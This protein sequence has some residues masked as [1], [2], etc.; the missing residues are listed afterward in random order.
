MKWQ[1]SY[2]ISVTSSSL[3]GNILKKIS[4]RGIIQTLYTAF[5]DKLKA[6]AHSQMQAQ[7][8]HY[9]CLQIFRME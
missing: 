3:A 1:F 9:V 2:N 6:F 8:E 7:E 4:C 5:T